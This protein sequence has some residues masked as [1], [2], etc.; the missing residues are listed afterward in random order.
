MFPTQITAGELRKLRGNARGIA[1]E[2]L[3]ASIRACK[4]VMS[5]NL[6]EPSSSNPDDYVVVGSRGTEGEPR[7]HQQTG[8]RISSA[9][10]LA[11]S[12]AKSGQ[13]RGNSTERSDDDD[14]DDDNPTV[15]DQR[16]EVV[17]GKRKISATKTVFDTSPAKRTARSAS[18]GSSAASREALPA[19]PGSTKPPSESAKASPEAAAAAR[20]AKWLKAVQDNDASME[21]AMERVRKQQE[22]IKEA[23]MLRTKELMQ[24][25]VDEQSGKHGDEGDEGPPPA[26]HVEA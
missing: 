24:W 6:E 4:K 13:V 14:D 22:E 11:T 15:D 2:R 9:S 16:V 26:K 12:I 8:A 17:V 1:I 21:A 23:H 7:D 5:S 10:S 18:Q 3:V 19:A 25:M 20:K